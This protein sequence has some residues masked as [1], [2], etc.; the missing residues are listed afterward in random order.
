MLLL[1]GGRIRCLKFESNSF[2]LMERP[3]HIDHVPIVSC[4]IFRDKVGAFKLSNMSNKDGV[5]ED[6]VVVEEDEIYG[7]SMDVDTPS[8]EPTASN[9]NNQV[10]AHYA[11]LYRSNGVLE[12]HRLS[13][14]ETVFYS[15]N[16]NSLPY[17]LD[18][19]GLSTTSSSI[20]KSISDVN[21]TEI[22]L[23]ALGPY[24]DPYLIVKT[25][26]NDVHI[27]RA[28]AVGT[29]DI[30]RLA[31]R[32]VKM[33]N[34]LILREPANCQRPSLPTDDSFSKRDLIPFFNVEGY[35]GVFVNGFIPIMIL[36]GPRR[37]IRIHKVLEHGPISSFTEMHTSFCTR[38]LALLTEM[39]N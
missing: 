36:V 7:A 15:A 27:Y 19:H 23:I 28:L 13:S 6:S 35:S 22:L 29:G 17:L 9:E 37:F 26:Q 11:A 5:V 16:F 30:N 2:Q 39:V 38:G 33:A 21:F 12:I 34:D 4:S 25:K 18:D 14:F 3:S 8:A 31:V 1:E 32:F 24:Q 20:V 10:L